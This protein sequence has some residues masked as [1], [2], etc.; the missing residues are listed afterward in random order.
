M[1]EWRHYVERGGEVDLH[2]IELPATFMADAELEE[3]ERLQKKII[4]QGTHIRVDCRNV[5]HMNSTAWGLII[6]AYTRA[7][8]S[9]GS[10]KLDATG[11]AYVLNFLRVTRL[12]QLNDSTIT[13]IGKPGSAAPGQATPP[14]P[15]STARRA[16]SMPN[17]GE[18]G[19]SPPEDPDSP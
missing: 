10:L 5:K 12:D 4:H 7:K 1:S 3:F 9:G 14:G 16:G 18:P 6:T 19:G 13:L 11:N 15:A 17:R 8:E 2:V